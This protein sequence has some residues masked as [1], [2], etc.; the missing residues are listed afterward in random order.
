M[1]L[2]LLI[3]DWEES[4]EDSLAI[5][6]NAMT[7]DPSSGKPAPAMYRDI[8][9]RITRSLDATT[10]N[11]LNFSSLLGS[12]LNEPTIFGLVDLSVGQTMTGMAELVNR[13]VLRDSARG[14][15]FANEM[16]RAATYVGVPQAIR[17][18]LHGKIA[19][20]LMEDLEKGIGD[21]GLEIAWHSIRAGKTEEAVPHL[22]RGARESMRRGA[23]HEAE[24]ALSSALPYL[25]N[26]EKGA[27]VLLLVELLQEQGRWAESLDLL[28]EE[29]SKGSITAARNQVFMISAQL[30]L[31][32]SDLHQLQESLQVLLAVIR[33]NDD[34]S[35][36][37]LAA[38]TAV[39]L[40]SSLRDH[41]LL[42]TLLDLATGIPTWS[43]T[44]EELSTLALVRARLKFFLGDRAASLE[45]IEA[46]TAFSADTVSTTAAQFQVGLGAIVSKLGDYPKGLAYLQNAYGIAQR[47]GNDDLQ[48]TVAANIAFV[49][50]RLGDYQGQLYWAEKSLSL[51]RLASTDYSEILA[52]YCAAF[53]CIFLNRSARA[54][55]L[56]TL[57]RD[58]VAECLPKWATQAWLLY[59]ADLNFLLG[60]H[61][62]AFADAVQATSG[63]NSVLHDRAFAGPFTRWIVRLGGNSREGGD[64]ERRMKDF[65][66]RLDSYDVLDKAEILAAMSYLARLTGRP[67]I[68]LETRLTNQLSELPRPVSE[69]LERLGML[70]N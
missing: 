4:G 63:R 31:Y 38:H 35:L 67:S 10:R 17:K 50:G 30:H 47:L 36:C 59:S 29:S 49:V 70:G 1:V 14:L 44:Q 33:E 54:E 3:Q 42:H 13:R 22:F 25:Q 5:S 46:A 66:L 40:A 20:H 21:L 60:H 28:D 16:V 8:L 55:E 15:E 19:A 34:P 45:E 26:H 39:A 57:A 52:I 61:R 11:V 62:E 64:A 2:E 23:L 18:L 41:A 32:G 27:A 9:N 58:R 65:Y 7:E 56:I 37:V 12:R 69:Q 53:A 68:E 48:S 6:I 24:R 51:R 43:L